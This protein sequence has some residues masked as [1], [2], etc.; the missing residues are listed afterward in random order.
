M[1]FEF[2]LRWWFPVY[3]PRGRIAFH[4]EHGAYLGQPDTRSRQWTNTGEFDVEVAINRHGFRD[5]RDVLDAG[6]QDI[7]VVGDS[8]SFGQGVEEGKRY[9]SLISNM[10]G[11]DFY[12]ISIPNNIDGYINLLKYAQSKGVPTRNV[13]VGVTMENDLALYPR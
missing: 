11:S 2:I 5:G 1:L 8:F 6:P 12:N 9:S 7:L 13:I 3:D 10:N 4:C